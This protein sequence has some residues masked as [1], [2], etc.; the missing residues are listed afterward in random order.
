[1]TKFRNKTKVAEVQLYGY[2][3]SFIKDGC[4]VKDRYWTMWNMLYYQRLNLVTTWSCWI[5][6]Q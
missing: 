1:V 5:W 4:D 6:C 3:F 2:M